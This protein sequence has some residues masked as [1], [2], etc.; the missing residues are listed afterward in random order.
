[1]TKAIGTR[2]AATVLLGLVL[3]V[4]PAAFGGKGGNGGKP[5]GGGGSSSLKLAPEGVPH[6]GQQV[7]F[8][9]T[10]TATT[11]PIVSVDCTQGGGVV[12]SSSRPMYWP[13]L[14]DDPGIFT[15]ASYAWSGGA[16]DCRASLIT[17][18]N[19]GRP[20]TLA[21]LGFHVDA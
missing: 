11:T 6:W 8:T 14:W 15:L 20:V 4:A 18:G 19:N 7:T 9:V 17:Q 5:S 3:V 13:N 2:I 16:A 21:T 10:T 1:M 12:Y